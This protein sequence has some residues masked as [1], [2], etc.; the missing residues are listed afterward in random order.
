MA[1]QGDGTAAGLSRNSDPPWTNSQRG[2]T[3][4][5]W[6]KYDGGSG[7]GTRVLA[8]TYNRAGTL[9]GEVR[10]FRNG[11]GLGGSANSNS[12][13]PIATTVANAAKTGVWVPVLLRMH[14][15]TFR[16]FAAGAPNGGDIFGRTRITTSMASHG[17]Q[18]GVSVGFEDIV[19]PGAF[20]L[21]STIIAH[22]CFWPAFL[23]DSEVRAFMSLAHPMD[24]RAMRRPAQYYPLVDNGYCAITG[25]KLADVGTPAWVYDSPQLLSPNR[26]RPLLPMSYVAAGGGGFLPAWARGAN[27]II[28]AGVVA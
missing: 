3:I 27:A 9:G 1:F 2:V 5:C 7:A 26:L 6:T 22:A 28:G 17:D 20:S 16:D 25:L 23:S 15:N 21:A 19:T 4:A 18:T 24:P 12:S 8:C 10:L 11:T 13:A 14:G